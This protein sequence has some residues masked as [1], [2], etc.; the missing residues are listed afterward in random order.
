[1]CEMRGM[2]R[3]YIIAMKKPITAKLGIVLECTIVLILLSMVGAN[4]LYGDKIRLWWISLW[5]EV[6]KLPQGVLRQLDPNDPLR[7]D[8]I[9][10]E[11]EKR[12][13]RLFSSPAQ[14]RR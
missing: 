8:G 14:Q 1:M 11:L 9:S 12:S 4:R 3:L 2:L 10:R 6:P 7:D 5:Y 13:E